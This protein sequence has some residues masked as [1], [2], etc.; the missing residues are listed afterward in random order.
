MMSRLD[1]YLVIFAK[2][3]KVC[4]HDRES[5]SV[6]R[7]GTILIL[8]QQKNWV[9]WMVSR[10]PIVTGN[11]RASHLAKHQETLPLTGVNKVNA[12]SM[13]QLIPDHSEEYTIPKS[14][15][16]LPR[17][18]PYCLEFTLNT[19]WV[20]FFLSKVAGFCYTYEPRGVGRS[21]KWSVLRK[22]S[23]LFMLT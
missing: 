1:L 9:A 17:R 13:N 2:S 19:Y 10:F 11:L 3:S 4:W 12:R 5:Q 16:A 18:S 14:Q 7:P 20:L 22:F 21:R 8:C 15:G 6:A 23:A